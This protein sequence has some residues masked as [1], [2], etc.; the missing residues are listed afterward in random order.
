MLFAPHVFR[1]Q[2]SSTNSFVDIRSGSES[3]HI[4]A[5][6]YHAIVPVLAINRKD[7]RL[8]L[9][10]NTL[11]GLVFALYEA[12]SWVPV[13]H[14]QCPLALQVLR[15]QNNGVLWLSLHCADA[16]SF[17]AFGFRFWV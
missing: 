4:L 11:F 14:N 3:G 10:H 6:H 13:T 15:W 16:L 8:Y 5:S 9:M 17:G 2:T 12:R 7:S 1:P